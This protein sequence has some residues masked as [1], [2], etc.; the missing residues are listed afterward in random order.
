MDP[1]RVGQL[2]EQGLDGATA[3]VTGD[4]RHFDAI[5][6]SDR[7]EGKNRVQRHR[8]VFGAVQEYLNDDAIHA[9]SLQTY[10]PEDWAQ[11]QA[12]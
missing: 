12:G 7:F 2:I 1:A 5:V 3:E 8:M 4:G 6:I 11:R 10:T 9:L